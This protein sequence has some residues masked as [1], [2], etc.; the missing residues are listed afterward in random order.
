M[1]R[2]SLLIGLACLSALAAT[3]AAD[4]PVTDGTARAMRWWNALDAEQMVA[5]LVGDEATP[6]QTAAAQKLYADLD[7]DTRAL[8]N[9]AADEISGFDSVGA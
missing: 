3:A 8:V 6:A 9:A 5:A 2:M 1:K 7:D 4:G